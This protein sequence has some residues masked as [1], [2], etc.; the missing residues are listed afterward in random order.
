MNSPLVTLE[1]LSAAYDGL[2][3]LRDVCLTVRE[4]D[5]LGVIGPNGGGKTTLVKLLLGLMKPSSGTIRYFRNGQSVSSVRMGYMPQYSNI[6]RQFPISVLQVVRSGLDR[7]VGLF[8]RYT[9]AQCDDVAQTIRRVG[10]EGLEH[11]PLGELSGGQLQ[12]AL[13]GRALVSNPDV[14]VLD[15]PTTYLDRRFEAE[16]YEL[17]AEANHRC[18]VILVSHDIDA[19]LQI[20]SSI[21]CVNG[22]LHYQPSASDVTTGWIGKHFEERYL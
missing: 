1:H 3:V 13:L 21:A 10:L 22:T 16:L 15:E 8:G 7:E 14:V 5:Y 9:S 12:R 19:V 6:D 4:R 20:A 11:R 2:E 17:L 18:A